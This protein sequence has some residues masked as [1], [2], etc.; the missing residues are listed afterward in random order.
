[1]KEHLQQCEYHHR[2][3]THGTTLYTV[4]NFPY[5]LTRNLMTNMVQI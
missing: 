4:T 1:M 2:Q 5:L 3:V